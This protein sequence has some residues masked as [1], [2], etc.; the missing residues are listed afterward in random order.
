[1]PSLADLTRRTW[2]DHT[3]D[4]HTSAETLYALLSDVD[5]W[6]SWTPGLR[7][8]KRREQGFVGPGARFVMHLAHPKFGE[9]KLPTVMYENQPLRMEWG[10]G[11]FGSVIRHSME[12]TPIDADHTRLRH[13]EYATGLL[14]LVTLPFE[15]F[16]Y[17]HDFRWSE[18]IRTRFE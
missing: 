9:V 8:I 5:G 10:G 7:A 17:D 13:V 14:A 15:K 18:T 16:A 1:M 11:G 12:L 6:P 4:V 2:I 3:C